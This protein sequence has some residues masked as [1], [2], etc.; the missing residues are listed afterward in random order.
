MPK[1]SSLCTY[2]KE[3]GLF[4]YPGFSWEAFYNVPE[5]DYSY[6]LSLGEHTLN[7]RVLGYDGDDCL[8]S[9]G[10]I[11]WSK[12]DEFEVI[13]SKD[14][15]FKIENAPEYKLGD[16]D[17]NG[18]ITVS[19]AIMVLQHVAK[20]NILTG[21]QLLAADVDKTSGNVTTSE[22]ITVSDAIKILQY[23]AKNI[24]SFD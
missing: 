23:V 6:K 1:G 17:N 13:Y 9:S 21:N 15:H 10:H 8:D 16:V 12:W 2:D 22:S 3:T 20:N 11:V 18:E 14:I 7:V 24:N 19:D 4:D 5:L